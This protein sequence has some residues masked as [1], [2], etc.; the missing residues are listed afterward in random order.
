MAIRAATSEALAKTEESCQNQLVQLT[1]IFE[2]ALKLRNTS[3]KEETENLTIEEITAENIRA[4]TSTYH[5]YFEQEDRETIE[6]YIS[7]CNAP[8]I[9]CGHGDS[10]NGCISSALFF[11]S[12][13]LADAI[14]VFFTRFAYALQFG[15]PSDA[16]LAKT[17]DLAK[18]AH[19][20]IV[21]RTQTV[22]RDIN[23]LEKKQMVVGD[24]YEWD[25]MH[26]TCLDVDTVGH[27]YTVCFF[28]QI[29][30][31][32]KDGGANVNLGYI[33]MF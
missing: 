11:V 17:P 24:R 26:D 7:N 21:D 19:L 30:Q 32:A 25:E 22:G 4:L 29:T 12:N 2:K 6:V 15:T 28:G 33:F 9:V 1:A 8:Q 13:T 5:Q 27:T 14:G 10:V 16:E 20:K 18:S 23:A 31:K 3:N